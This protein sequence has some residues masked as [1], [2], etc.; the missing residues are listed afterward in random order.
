MSVRVALLGLALLVSATGRPAAALDCARAVAQVEMTACAQL[1]WEE[2]D[3]ALNEAYA[4]ARAAMQAVGPEAAETLRDAQRAWI[5]YRDLACL[6][7]A[8]PYAGGTAQPMIHAA[9]LER[10]TSQ[11]TADLRLLAGPG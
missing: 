8:L 2:A 10:L 1:A 9:C 6:A 7:E 11:R 5:G 3:I 4:A